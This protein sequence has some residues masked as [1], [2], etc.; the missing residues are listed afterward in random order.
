MNE[1]NNNNMK[2]LT[3]FKKHL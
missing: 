1:L 3:T 2:I